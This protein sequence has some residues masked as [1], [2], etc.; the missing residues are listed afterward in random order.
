VESDAEVVG[1]RL[2]WMLRLEIEIVLRAADVIGSR[3]KS[4]SRAEGSDDGH[5]GHT[6]FSHHHHYKSAFYTYL[7][8]L[9]RNGKA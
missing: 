6:N 4:V 7:V 1:R 5:N 9:D 3:L 8:P 2:Y